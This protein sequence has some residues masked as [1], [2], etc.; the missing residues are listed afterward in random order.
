MP[1]I[2]GI[3][4]TALYVADLDA[5]QRFY[6]DLFGFP[7]MFSDPRLRALNVTDQQVLLLFQQG[8]S[9]EANIIPGG[10]IPAHDGAGQLHLACAIAAS[11]LEPWRRKLAEQGVALESTVSWERGGTSIY[12]RDPDQ[13][14]L[15]LVTP[16]CWPNY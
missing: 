9:F 13:H 16:G 4:E 6:Q 15:E 2:T 8:A 5:A 10:V 3:L 14:L 7:L 1:A 11:E 12:F